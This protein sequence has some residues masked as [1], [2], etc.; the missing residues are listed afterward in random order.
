MN[1][2][3]R[4][5][6]KVYIYCLRRIC[7]FSHTSCKDIQTP[8]SLYIIYRISDAGYPKIKPSYINNENCLRN[9]VKRFPLD[10]CR[11]RI[12][13]DNVCDDTYS[14][15]CT[16]IPKENIQRV[17]VGHGAGTFRLAMDFA[18]SLPDSTIVYF[19]ENDYLHKEHAMDVLLEGFTLPHCDYIT[20]YDHP[21]KYEQTHFMAKGGEKSR[22]YLTTS[23]HWKIS[24]STTM[25]FAVRVSTLR[26]DKQV[27]NRWTM[28]R[29]PYDFEIFFNLNWK[30]RRLL[31][32]IPGYATHG[33]TDGHAP[34]HNW[35]KETE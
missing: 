23:T 7:S 1:Y 20:L 14:M 24:H 16:Y 34:L 22:V 4:F 21:D 18:L 12:I 2:L 5:F 27:F 6:T 9:A 28:T 35:S 30:G 29:H 33:D 10:R 17:S 3:I 25:T 19:L 15:I 31:L 11:W 8:D 26:C 32:P 13:A